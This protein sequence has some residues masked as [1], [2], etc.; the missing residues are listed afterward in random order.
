MEIKLKEIED[1]I[2]SK[3]SVLSKTRQI[4]VRSNPEKF[5]EEGLSFTGLGVCL[6]KIVNIQSANPKPLGRQ[7]AQLEVSIGLDLIQRYLSSNSHT[8]QGGH[9]LCYKTIEEI[10]F[11]IL[12]YKPIDEFGFSKLILKKMEYKGNTKEDKLWKY[13]LEFNMNIDFIQE[14]C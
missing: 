13:Y 7:V 11:L 14:D 12:G 10:L 4:G 8:S 3:L 1:N 5:E 2:V 6:V 9:F